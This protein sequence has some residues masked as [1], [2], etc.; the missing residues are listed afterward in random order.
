MLKGSKLV[1]DTFLAEK[2]FLLYF[3]VCL[4][5]QVPINNKLHQS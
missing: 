3:N 4:T 2:V 1:L 5:Q